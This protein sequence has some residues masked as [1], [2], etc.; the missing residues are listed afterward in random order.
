MSLHE[1]DQQTVQG[2]VGVDHQRGCLSR[3]QAPA[4]SDD[5]QLVDERFAKPKKAFDGVAQRR[6]AARGHGAVIAG[7]LLRTGEKLRR[8]RRVGI[9]IREQIA[10]ESHSALAEVVAFCFRHSRQ[11][12]GLVA[13]S[14]GPG[15]AIRSGHTI[16]RSKRGPSRPA[17]RDK[18]F[19][20]CEQKPAVPARGGKGGNLSSIGPSPQGAG[21][22]AQRPAGLTKRQPAPLIPLQN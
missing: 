14:S 2:G 16:G 17:G 3:V 21:R 7:L 10:D 8:E 20:R 13:R 4:A 1:S 22:D 15:L 6:T 19:D 5:G 9:E 18:R 11:P 12:C